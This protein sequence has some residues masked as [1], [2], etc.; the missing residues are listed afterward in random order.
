MEDKHLYMKHC[1]ILCGKVI[2]KYK[3][4]S[5]HLNSK[6]HKQKM[7]EI[8][9][10]RARIMK[11][12]VRTDKLRELEERLENVIVSYRVLEGYS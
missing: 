7:E 10:E 6:I 11:E 5:R 12:V 1:C 8:E 2:G 4:L 3:F 9:Q